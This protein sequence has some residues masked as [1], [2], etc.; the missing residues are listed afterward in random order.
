VES[1]EDMEWKD[2]KIFEE[3]YGSVGDSG[4]REIWLAG[5]WRLSGMG[6]KI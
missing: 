5:M 6:W 2:C 1:D 4:G 3:I